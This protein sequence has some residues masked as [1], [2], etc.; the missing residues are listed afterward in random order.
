MQI[1]TENPLQPVIDPETDEPKVDAETDE[2]IMARQP[3]RDADGTVIDYEKKQV[4][5]IRWIHC[6]SGTVQQRVQRYKK[7]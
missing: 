5:A 6:G 1:G 4:H 2:I 7:L 3:Y